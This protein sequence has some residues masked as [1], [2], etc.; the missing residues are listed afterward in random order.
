MVA[1]KPNDQESGGEEADGV[2]QQIKNNLSNLSN[3]SNWT[4]LDKLLV[5]FGDDTV[6]GGA[7]SGCGNN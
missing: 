3:L 4:N 6:S 5:R 2:D 7:D 1:G